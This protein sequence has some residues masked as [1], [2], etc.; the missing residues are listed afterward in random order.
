MKRANQATKSFLQNCLHS[1]RRFN[2]TLA[3]AEIG[4]QPWYPS[5][6][7]CSSMSGAFLK[8]GNLSVSIKDEKKFGEL[9]VWLNYYRPQ[10]QR[11]MFLNAE[12][13]SGLNE[14]GICVPLLYEIVGAFE[15]DINFKI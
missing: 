9:V 14:F 4:C 8:S 7:F 10:W 11:L 6:I 1:S 5:A 3:P 12:H 2:S 13:R 15:Y